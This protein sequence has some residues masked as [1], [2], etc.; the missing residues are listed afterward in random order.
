MSLDINSL[1]KNPSLD[2][3]TVYIIELVSIYAFTLVVL[4]MVVTQSQQI[5]KLPKKSSA[6]NVQQTQIEN[7]VKALQPISN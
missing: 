4:G 1:S 2:S 5:F 3:R 7:A 6:A